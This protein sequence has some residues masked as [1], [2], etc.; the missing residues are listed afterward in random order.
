MFNLVR[1]QAAGEHYRQSG[2][3][4]AYYTLGTLLPVWLGAVVLYLLSKPIG[5][6]TFLDNG[7]FAIY[8]AA[9]LGATIYIL[10][11]Q[12][13]G[14]ENNLY[15][16]IAIVCLILAAA[17][18]VALT[19]SEALTV[20]HLPI[21][22]PALR[23]L[24]LAL[25]ATSVVATFYTDL[26]QTVDHASAYRERREQGQEDLNTEFEREKEHFPKPADQARSAWKSLSNAKY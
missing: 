11:R 15:V 2:L 25:Y 9:A 16:L 3:Y 10:K 22:T 12:D 18:Y 8:A 26:Y 23:V 5:L 14:N 6:G 1:H 20:A 24:S 4:V 13:S 21:N 17:I 19:V 7:Q